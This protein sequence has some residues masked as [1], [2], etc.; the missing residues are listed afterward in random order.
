MVYLRKGECE[1]RYEVAV[2]WTTDGGFL[3][4]DKGAGV[5]RERLVG[6]FSRQS[7]AQAEC[8]RLNAAS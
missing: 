5:G 2:D 7:D 4:W 3:V 6:R 8:D 1:M